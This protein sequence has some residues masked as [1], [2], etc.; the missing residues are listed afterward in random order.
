MSIAYATRRTLIIP[1]LLPHMG[2]KTH[3]KFG[4]RA[5]KIYKDGNAIAI[6]D[7]TAVID[8]NKTSFPSW[9]EI[10][11]Y[12]LITESTGVHVMD[13]WDFM[14][15][16]FGEALLNYT[17]EIDDLPPVSDWMEFIDNFN[18]HFE[19][20]TLALIGSA[21]ALKDID[22]AFKLFDEESFER[23]RIATLGFTPSDK[24]LNLARAAIIHIPKH[25]VGVHMRFGDMYHLSKCDEKT[26]AEE[27]NKLI[28]N[29]RDAN[30]TKG[31]AIYIGSKDVNA[32]KCFDQHS[33]FD[34][35]LFALDDI[36]SPLPLENN[37]GVYNI[38]AVIPSLS[39]AMNAINLDIGTKYL[40]I[41]LT[42]VSLGYKYFFSLV[43][44][45]PKFSTFQEVIKQ[46][47]EFRSEYLGL[48]LGKSSDHHH[49]LKYGDA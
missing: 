3:T 49:L 18:A 17:I 23:I 28:S 40:L 5:G 39:D 38:S 22:D 10:L 9:S 31:S 15:T 14:R 48:I 29:I 30:I 13:V 26:A 46:R 20:K 32:K 4:A 12:D 44:F 42:L 6:N 25:Y 1:P 8:I 35:S 45:R 19:N 21:F 33:Q 47:H 11:D 36:T 41:D 2:S 27:F 34:F 43:S 24:I 7:G 37:F 16:E